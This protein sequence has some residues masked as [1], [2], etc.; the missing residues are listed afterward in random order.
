MSIMA[1]RELP[2]RELTPKPDNNIEAIKR[3]EKALARMIM[4]YI[5]TGLAFMLL[6]GTF[7][8]VWN[9]LSISAKQSS[10]TISP[11]WI[12]AHGQAQV[13]GW[14]GS[15]ILGIGFYS[16]PKMRRAQAFA[17]SEAWLCWALW[18]TAV[19]LRWIAGVYQ[20]HWRIYIQ[21][22]FRHLHTVVQGTGPHGFS[23]HLSAGPPAVPGHEISR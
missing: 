4:T 20:W 7:L 18:T 23:E 17:M 21:A 15:F 9:L 16:I 2:F 11:A 8:G 3:R 12:Q 10:N 1:I 5:G 22:D 6:P 19:L 13:F 14:I